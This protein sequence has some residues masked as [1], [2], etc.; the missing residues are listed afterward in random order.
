MDNIGSGNKYLFMQVIIIIVIVAS[1]IVFEG[2]SVLGTSIKEVVINDDGS[3]IILKTKDLT[4]EEVISKNGINIRK[5]DNVY[6]DKEK[7]L[8]FKETN[9]IIIKRAVLVTVIVDNKRLD[10]FTHNTIIKDIFEENQIEFGDEDIL[11]G[12][13]IDDSI[14]PGVTLRIIRVK[15]DLIKE[16]QILTFTVEK[17]P[18]QRLDQGIEKTVRQGKEG[19]KEFLYKVVYEDGELKS[20]ELVKETI[21]IAPTNELVEYGTISKY[22]S[23]RGE[24]FRY[25]QV[26]DMNSTA[27]TAS[28]K[29]TGKGPDHPHYGLTYTGIKAKRGIVAVDPKV[30]PLGTKLYIEGVGKVADYG[31]ALAADIG[32]AVKNNMIDLYVETQKEADGWGIKKVKVYILAD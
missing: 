9:N 12:A 25:K 5:E 8:S 26:L 13:K 15:E 4:I 27:Y 3:E 23:S 1:V 24:S 14:Y 31:Y 30:I 7:L 20:K 21:V 18:N 16:E 29:D 10:I 19:V 11:E 32:G 17:R 22:T 2:I 28:F 6:P